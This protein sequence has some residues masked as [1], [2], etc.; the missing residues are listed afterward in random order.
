VDEEKKM[1][2]TY[3]DV[4]ELIRKIR[5]ELEKLG[6]TMRFLNYS[7]GFLDERELKEVIDSCYK[8]RRELL[9]FL[10]DWSEQEF[11]SFLKRLS[12]DAKRLL[13]AIV[14]MD[15]KATNGTLKSKLGW[16]S[17]KITGI[18]AGITNMA[19]KSGHRSPFKRES[20]RTSNG[21]WDYLYTIDPKVLDWLKTNL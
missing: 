12:P 6:A 11:L 2:V 5:E 7:I 16:D 19:R 4:D 20:V 8:R 9:S 15:G 10:K 3:R 14:E 18:L 17:M 21:K 13:K 1:E